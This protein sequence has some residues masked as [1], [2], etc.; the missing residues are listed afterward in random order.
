MPLLFTN[1]R[2]DLVMVRGQ[3]SELFDRTGRRYL[4]FVQ[5]WAVNCLGHCPEELASALATQSRELLTPSPA[6]HNE[7]ALEVAADLTRLSGLDRAFLCNS[8]AEANECAVKLARKWGR[9][10][11]GGAV[12]V[13][14]THQGFHGRTLAMMAASGKDGWDGLFPPNLEGFVKVPFGDVEAVDRAIGERTAA[15]LVEPIQGEAGVIVPPEGY[16]R[17]LRTLA[18]ERGV[19]LMFDEIQ[20]GV[21]RTGT[22][23]RFEQEGARP[24]VMTLGKGLGGGVP[25]AAVVAVRICSR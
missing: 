18:D 19:L 6:Y 7:R 15:I 5:G 22:F 24:D 3:G 23:F 21:G 14:T 1:V 13:V 20:T 16:L 9:L 11:K 8:G 2:P 17:A 25:V 12:E 4:D 10:H